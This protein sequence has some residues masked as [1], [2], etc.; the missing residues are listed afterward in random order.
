M[1]EDYPSVFTGTCSGTNMPTL[2]STKSDETNEKVTGKYPNISLMDALTEVKFNAIIHTDITEELK[3]L[4]TDMEQYIDQLS[5]A[6]LGLPEE[7]LEIALHCPVEDCK[8][9]LKIKSFSLIEKMRKISAKGAE[10]PK[11]LFCT[12]CKMACT[13]SSR[14]N[15]ALD[16][17][18]QRCF[19]RGKLNQEEVIDLKC[20]GLPKK[21]NEGN[22]VETQKW[23]LQLSSIQLDV[24]LHDWKHRVSCFKKG[25][26][27]CRYKIPFEP[28]ESTKVVPIFSQN[29]GKN[30]LN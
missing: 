24:N 15:A 28:V 6:E 14:L 21:P 3:H 17:G 13:I 4:T 27:K 1:K 18:F 23:L 7:E 29:P 30:Q 22:I 20:K 16:H 11:A 26:G 12:I 25:G 2:D 19:G 5:T 10:E 9:A 8:G